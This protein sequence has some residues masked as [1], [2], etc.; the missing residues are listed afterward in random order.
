MIT[1]CEFPNKLKY[2][3][4]TYVY[5]K[6]DRTNIRNYGAVCL[7]PVVSKLFEILLSN[8]INKYIDPYLSFVVSEKATVH[9]IA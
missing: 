5:R 2:G 8:E 1:T 9:S 7:L 3:D 6:E 4:I